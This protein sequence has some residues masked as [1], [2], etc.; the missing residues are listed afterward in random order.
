MWSVANKIVDFFIPFFL[1]V[2]MCMSMQVYYGLTIESITLTFGLSGTLEL[3]EHLRFV[4]F[5]FFQCLFK[6]KRKKK[7]KG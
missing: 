1:C 5:L 4:V 3:H 7:D 6:K 2:C